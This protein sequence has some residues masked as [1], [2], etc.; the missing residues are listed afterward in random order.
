MSLMSSL[1]E[2]AATLAAGKTQT[3]EVKRNYMAKQPTPLRPGESPRPQPPGPDLVPI[4]DPPEQLHLEP[5]EPPMRASVRAP[6]RQSRTGRPW[7][8]YDVIGAAIV[9]F[10]VALWVLHF[11]LPAPPPLRSVG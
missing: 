2:Q 4:K 11:L 10:L 7:D 1:R 8:R 3:A 9:I 5:V 6:A